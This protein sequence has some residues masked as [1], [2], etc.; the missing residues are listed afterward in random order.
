LRHDELIAAGVE[1]HVV[2][3]ITAAEAILELL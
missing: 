1:V 2:Y 3:S